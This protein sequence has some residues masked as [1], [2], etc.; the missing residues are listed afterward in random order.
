MF[1]LNIDKKQDIIPKENIGRIIPKYKRTINFYR[2]FINSNH[3]YYS[4]CPLNGEI[5]DAGINGW[6]RRE[7][8]LK[9]YEMAYYS[10]GDILEFGSYH[11][12]STSIISKANYDSGLKKKILSIDIDLEASNIATNN[13]KK[14]ELEKNV[15]FIVNNSD[16]I[17]DNLINE[18]KEFNFV[19][20][21]H[22]HQYQPVYNVCSR[23]DELVKKGGFCLFHDYNDIRN[24]DN[25][26]DDYGV[27]QA[28][29]DGLKANNFEHYGDFGC[30]A[31]F[32]K[33]S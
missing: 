6:L 3:K 26:N 5:I 14:L 4:E 20:V 27:Y 13:L 8:A 7:D 16:I 2:R 24:I 33:I 15:D 29:H 11:G 17:I 10:K 23:L 30:T 12:L 1:R 22:S 28:V 19:F 32:K 9:I 25:E 18:K 31:L 21:D